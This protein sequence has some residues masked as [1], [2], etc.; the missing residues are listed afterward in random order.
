MQDIIFIDKGKI[1][2]QESIDDLKSKF[3]TVTISSD[4]EAELDN[5]LLKM[6]TLGQ[7][8]GIVSSETKIEDAIEAKPSLSDLFL[9]IVGGN[10]A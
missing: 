4:R 7:V 9:A 6:K 1:V 10:H 3:K 8:S 5:A 2:L